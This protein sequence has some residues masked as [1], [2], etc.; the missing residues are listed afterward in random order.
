VEPRI[1][2]TRTKIS[3]FFKSNRWW[4]RS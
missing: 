4:R 2:Y 3:S 1:A